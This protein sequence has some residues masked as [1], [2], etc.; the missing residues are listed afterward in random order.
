MDVAL[1][2]YDNDMELFRQAVEETRNEYQTRRI[3]RVHFGQKEMD[4]IYNAPLPE[5][6]RKETI[7]MC[8]FCLKPLTGQIA[9][10]RHQVCTI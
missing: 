3:K 6:F 2:P 8:E 9:F 1:R 4:T 10:E 7:Y 5:E